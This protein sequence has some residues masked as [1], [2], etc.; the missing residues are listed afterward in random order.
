MSNKK[1]FLNHVTKSNVIKF[2]NKDFFERNKEEIVRIYNNS[3]II[4]YDDDLNHAVIGNVDG[5]RIYKWKRLDCKIV[6]F[7]EVLTE[8]IFNDK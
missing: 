3:Y 1:V 5:A 7:R 6:H 2:F 8:K 4:R